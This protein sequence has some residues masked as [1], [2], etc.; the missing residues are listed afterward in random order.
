M[1][2]LLDALEEH[3]DVDTAFI[4]TNRIKKNNSVGSYTVV[5]NIVVMRETRIRQDS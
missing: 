5:P 3:V 2:A 1:I 4:I